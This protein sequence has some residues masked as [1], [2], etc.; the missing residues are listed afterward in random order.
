ATGG[1]TATTDGRRPEQHARRLGQSELELLR[2]LQADPEITLR[3][4]SDEVA[5]CLTIL[6]EF[7]HYHLERPPKAWQILHREGVRPVPG[8]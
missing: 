8:P 2:A 5:G 4:G 6:G 3:P 1:L 7:L